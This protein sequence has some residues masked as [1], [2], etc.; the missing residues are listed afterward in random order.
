[1]RD[2]GKDRGE[3][4]GEEGGEL[5]SP[6]SPQFAAPPIRSAVLKNMF[7]QIGQVRWGE[8]QGAIP[9]SRECLWGPKLSFLSIHVVT[10]VF[11]Y[12]QL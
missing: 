5:R 11:F 12:K 6:S 2:G 4:G 3:Q 7:P 8:G 1:M 10:F 9:Y